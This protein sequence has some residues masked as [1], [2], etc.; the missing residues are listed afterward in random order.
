MDSERW[1]R[2]TALFGAA[3]ELPMGDRPTFLTENER[4]ATV[5]TLV[6][7]LLAADLEPARALSATAEQLLFPG[8][9]P[10][11]DAADRDR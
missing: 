11:R 1:K 10:R 6:S 7:D 3:I 4:D 8:R 9:T 5:R 2:V